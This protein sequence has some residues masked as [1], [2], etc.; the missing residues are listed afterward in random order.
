M[1]KIAFHINIITVFEE[2]NIRIEK[3]KENLPYFPVN[4]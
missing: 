4:Y 2:K 3:I 1:N